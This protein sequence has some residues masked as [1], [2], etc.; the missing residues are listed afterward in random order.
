MK[1]EVVA[2]RRDKRRLQRLKETLIEIPTRLIELN[3][4]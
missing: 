2:A 3:K 1:A 4:H